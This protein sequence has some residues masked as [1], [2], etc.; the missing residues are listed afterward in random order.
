MSWH[1][2][3]LGTGCR[4]CSWVRREFYGL[5][6]V[7]RLTVGVPKVTDCIKGLFL[8]I[9]EMLFSLRLIVI[10]KLVYSVV[11]RVL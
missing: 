7:L 6:P 5:V 10:L 2:D 8:G 4:I 9:G 11:W 3:D 1:V